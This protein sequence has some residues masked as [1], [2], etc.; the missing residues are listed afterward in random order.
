M[1]HIV[2]NDSG[3]AIKRRGDDRPAGEAAS[4]DLA[5][6]RVRMLG[7]NAPVRVVLHRDDGTIESQLSLDP[8]PPRDWME[9]V[10]SPP[11]LMGVAGAL[12]VSGAAALFSF[13]R[14]E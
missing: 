9:W 11:V 8:L 1:F 10:T 14:R 13:Y 12:V 2:P 3:W 4:R 5:V 7:R 6:E